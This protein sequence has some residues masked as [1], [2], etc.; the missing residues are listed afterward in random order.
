[1][2]Q[3][4]IALIKL[5]MKFWGRRFQNL[6]G[7]TTPGPQAEL[8]MAFLRIASPALDDLLR[9]VT[10][11]VYFE[12]RAA[13]SKSTDS[14]YSVIWLPGANR[15]AALHRLKL[16]THGLS[17]VR[18]KQRY[19]IRVIATYEEAA[20]RDLRPGEPFVKV[21]ISKIYRLHPSATWT[22]TATGGST[23][24]RMEMVGKASPALQRFCR[25]V[26]HG[27]SGPLQSHQPMSCRPS[28]RMS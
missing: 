28:T 26:A 6:E 8:F 18:M 12:P 4:K 16:T 17:L 20:H 23:S 5:F 24:Q 15:E 3:L 10:D 13:G 21:D 7:K 27:K 2:R 9:V 19:G 1:M 22:S 25:W 11:G 14:D